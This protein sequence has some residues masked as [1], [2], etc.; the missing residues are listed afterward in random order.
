MG[1]IESEVINHSSPLIFVLAVTWIAKSFNL[2]SA[3]SKNEG[4]IA[5]VIY[6]TG[7]SRKN[8]KHA[9]ERLRK[10]EDFAHHY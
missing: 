6:H 5:R 2:F 4:G 7:P 3:D 9:F 10:K 1:R 8:P